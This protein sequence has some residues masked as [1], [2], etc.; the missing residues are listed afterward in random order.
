MWSGL[1][2]GLFAV[3]FPKTFALCGS[4][5]LILLPN[6]RLLKEH[7]YSVLFGTPSQAVTAAGIV[8]LPTWPTEQMLSHINKGETVKMTRVF[9]LFLTFIVQF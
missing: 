2:V 9:F 6:F 8:F 5:D 3:F 4:A 1:C 7:V